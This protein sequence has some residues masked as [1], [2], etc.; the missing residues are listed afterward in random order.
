METVK[1]ITAVAVLLSL[2]GTVFRKHS[3]IILS[4]LTIAGVIIYRT[5]LLGYP[6]IFDGFDTILLFTAVFNVTAIASGVE[7]RL[8]GGISTLFLT[9][10]LLLPA[11]IKSIPSIIRTPLF[12]VHVGSA[13]LSYAIF[14][15]CSILVLFDAKAKIMNAFKWGFLLFTISLLAGS[16]WAFLAWGEIFMID[17]KSIFSLGL[18][19]FSAFVLHSQYDT[20]LKTLSRWMVITNGLLVVFLFLAVNFIFGGTHEF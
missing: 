13:L 8:S 9:G 16:I 6:P 18:W 4:A 5:V 3:A 20:K 2:L 15:S 11:E 7:S 12:I 17:P 10:S 1:L 14:L 19:L